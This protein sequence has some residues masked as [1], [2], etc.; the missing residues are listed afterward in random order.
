HDSSRNH[1]LSRRSAAL[2]RQW[3]GRP[4]LRNAHHSGALAWLRFDQWTKSYQTRR[5]DRLSIGHSRVFGLHVPFV[6]F[7]LARAAAMDQPAMMG[8]RPNNAFKPK[9]LRSTNH[10]AGRACHV[11]GSTTQ[12]G[13]T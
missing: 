2:V 7:L 8:A 1:N 6:A 9:P 4:I 12:L 13:L 10:M 3:C 5:A 11:F